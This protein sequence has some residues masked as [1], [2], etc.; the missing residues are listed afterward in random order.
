M[1]LSSFSLLEKERSFEDS[2]ILIVFYPLNSAGVLRKHNKFDIQ[3]N[4][5]KLFNSVKDSSVLSS[6]LTDKYFTILKIK[7]N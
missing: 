1:G 4:V 7:I 5:F 2:I 3:N 6:S